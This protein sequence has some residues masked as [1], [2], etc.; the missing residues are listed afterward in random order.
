MIAVLIALLLPAV[1]MAREAARRAQCQNNL[2]Q[3]GLALHNYHHTHGFFPP[4]FGPAA[5]A[6]CNNAHAPSDQNWSMKVFLL[7]YLDRADVYNT[8]NL[9]LPATGIRGGWEGDPNATLRK[10]R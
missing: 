3:I 1:R 8:A 10:A 9:D 7:P 4:D 2:K 5:G 6:R